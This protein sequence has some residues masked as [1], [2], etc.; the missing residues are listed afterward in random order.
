MAFSLPRSPFSPPRARLASRIAEP[1]ERNKAV[2]PTVSIVLLLCLSVIMPPIVLTV[3]NALLVSL[4]LLAVVA[5]NRKVDSLLLWIGV[6]FTLMVAIGLISGAGNERYLYLKDAWYVGNPLLVICIGYI[7]YVNKPDLQ[8]GLRAFVIGGLIVAIWQLRPYF[9]YPELLLL[10]AET[11]RRTIGA[12]FYAPVLAIVILMVF[13][14]RWREQLR[15]P[16]WL[17][18]LLGL[19]TTAAVV[20]VFSRTALMV[21]ILGALAAFGCFAKREWLRLLLPLAILLLSAFVLQMV[22]DTDSDKAMQTYVGKLARTVQ[23]I[24]VSD[25]AGFRDINLN[26]RGH[27]TA[28]AF[29]QYA[30]ADLLRL[31]VGQGFG[32]LVDLGVYLPLEFNEVGERVNVRYISTLHNG[33]AFILIKTGAL[34]TGIYIAVLLLIYLL[35]RKS[36]ALPGADPDR[37]PARLLQAVAVILA[38]STY[39]VGGVFNKQDMFPLLMLAGF[40]IAHFRTNPDIKQASAAEIPAAPVHDVL[41]KAGNS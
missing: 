21:V 9:Y 26:F 7:I 41:S 38:A 3:L 37:R 14:G 13:F 28:R 34:G 31:I 29:A 39:I 30:D 19:L 1:R 24:T 23:E 32:A 17:A 11:I 36:A 5:S 4:A 15:M 20:G 33:Y 25:Y 12:G 2:W 40:L 22:V 35:G 18:W 6:A 8:R 27:E 16:G 10:P